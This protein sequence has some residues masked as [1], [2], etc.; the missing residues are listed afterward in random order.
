MGVLGL[1]EKQGRAPAADMRIIV[2][3]AETTTAGQ[4]TYATLLRACETFLRISPPLVGVVR[5][6]MKVRVS[7]RNQTPLLIRHPNSDA[8]VDVEDIARSLS[9]TS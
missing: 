2:N 3:M 9:R 4:Q 7:I 6:D 8:A 5:R 1:V